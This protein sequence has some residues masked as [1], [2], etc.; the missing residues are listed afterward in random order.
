[1]LFFNSTSR[2]LSGL[3]IVAARLDSR[4]AQVMALAV[5]AI[6]SLR[7]ASDAANPSTIYVYPFGSTH[8]EAFMASLSGI[9][10]RTSPEVFMAD[11]SSNGSH[12]PEFWLNEF[13]EDNPATAVVWQNSLPFYIDR[14]KEKLSG[15]VLY[16]NTTINE[17]TSVAGATGAVMVHESLLPSISTALST[18]SLSQVADVRTHDSVWVYANYGSLLNKNMIFRQM[19]SFNQQLRSLAVLNAGFVFDNTGATRD[20]FLAGQNDN[21][22]VFGWG[23]GGNETEFFGSA[24]QNNLMGVPADHLSGSAASAKWQV[25]VPAQPAHTPTNTPTIANKHY[26]AFVMS[27]GDNVQWLTNDFARDTRW[28]GSPYRGDFD[29]TFDMSPSLLDVNPVALKYFYDEA[30]ADANKTFFVTAGGWGLNYPSQ[31][32]DI[33]GFMNATVSSMQAV[34]QNI[35]SVLDDSP[36]LAKLQQM[37]ERPEVLGL[38]LKTGDAYA[39]QHGAINWRDGKPIASVKYTL[40]DGFDTPN[41]IIGSLNGAPT[42]PLHNQGSYSIVNVHPWS[43]GTA[44]G[45]T[46]NPMSNVKY[47]VDHLDPDVEVVTLEE[48]MIHLRNNYG[49]LAAS[50]ASQN[51]MVNGSF[52]TPAAGNPSRPSNWFYA[53]GAG[54]TQLVIGQ[55]STGTG[56]KA[57]AINQMNADW[58]SAEFVV[59]PG[60]Q[61]TFSFDFMFNGVP[62][63]SGFRADARFFT[64]GSSFAG[65]TVQFLNAANYAAGVWHNFTTTAVVPAGATIG[66]IRFSTFFGAFAAGQVLIDDVQL[67]RFVGLA[68]DYNGDQRVDG[69][70]YVLWRN[71]NGQ[72]VN[73]GTGADG[74]RNGTIDEGDYLVWRAAYG[75]TAGSGASTDNVAVPEPTTEILLSFMALS[76]A[77]PRLLSRTA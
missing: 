44:G 48:L 5:L 29:F 53:A 27:D 12:D 40:W 36:N 49:T 24:S 21:T 7:T 62:N 77:F 23:Y 25:N 2:L 60:E 55:D 61:L 76:A 46:G 3:C 52:E 39:G 10:A 16:N 43:T 50:P 35:I 4:R 56:T 11:Q 68:G 28:F 54:Q 71:S 13:V 74:D 73:I 38:M 66:D 1:M 75:N 41:S 32:L 58:R 42:D 69:G 22:R 47:I 37:V 8:G 59:Q 63:G 51:V 65:E 67:L 18:A 15:Y 17:A 57:A 9:L 31:T 64:A 72:T 20:T 70:D 6:F 14:Y 30:A 33:N 34:D 45:G 26:V 19:P